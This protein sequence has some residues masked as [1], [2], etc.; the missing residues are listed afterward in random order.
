MEGA[1]GAGAGGVLG[2]DGGE[3]DD[4]GNFAGGDGFGDVGEE[5]GFFGEEIGGLV[6]G[7]ADDVGGLGGG[8]EGG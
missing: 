2:A 3:D 8:E 6:G 1:D 5:F 7:R 4:V